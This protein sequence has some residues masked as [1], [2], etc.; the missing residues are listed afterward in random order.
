MYQLATTVK[1]DVSSPLFHSVQ[2]VKFLSALLTSLNDC[3]VSHLQG[4]REHDQVAVTYGL[5]LY[6]ETLSCDVNKMKRLHL[7]VDLCDQSEEWKT[8]RK[9]LSKR[10][11]DLADNLSDN[12]WRKR[13]SLL[14]AFSL[15]PNTEL[16]DQIF[17]EEL[18]MLFLV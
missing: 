11:C 6:M 3:Y 7:E 2:S 5:E 12:K 9:A 14:T 8:L 17:G 10:Y 13:G 18:Q 4:G 1:S 15:N 16:L